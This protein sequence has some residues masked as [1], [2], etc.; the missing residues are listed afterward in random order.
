MAIQ[1]AHPWLNGSSRWLFSWMECGSNLEKN[2]EP[3]LNL[4]YPAYRESQDDNHCFAASVQ[5]WHDCTCQCGF[6]RWLLPNSGVSPF[7]KQSKQDHPASQKK[8]L[9]L[10]NWKF[11]TYCTL[12]IYSKVLVSYIEWVWSMNNTPFGN[13]VM[14]CWYGRDIHRMLSDYYE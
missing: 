1:D 9:L 13:N 12:V 3:I 2:Q 10:C 5:K 6:P 14:F 11:P 4:Y 8:L 7:R